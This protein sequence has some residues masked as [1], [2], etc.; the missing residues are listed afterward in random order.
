M[1]T[2]SPLDTLR[3]LA[4][5][6]ADDAAVLLGKVRQSHLNVQKQLEMLLDYETDY[7]QQLQSTMSSGINSANWYNYQQFL[8]TLEKAIEQHRKQLAHW[9]RQ[10]QQATQTWRTK[11]QRLNAFTTLQDRSAQKALL[12]ANRQDQ[13]LMDEFAQRASLRKHP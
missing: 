8:L 4:K 7:R 11:Y 5:Q 13:K 12:Y 6:E 1:K 9:N 10:L 3:D 2:Q